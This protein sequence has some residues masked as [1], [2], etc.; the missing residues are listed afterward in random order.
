[1]AVGS[2]I[3]LAESPLMA[4]KAER[5]DLIQLEGVWESV[6]D[7]VDYIQRLCAIRACRRKMATRSV[8]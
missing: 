4:I 6:A 1:M 3:H 5:N 2:K 7:A 8:L